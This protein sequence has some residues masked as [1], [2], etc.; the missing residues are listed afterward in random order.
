MAECVDCSE[1]RAPAGMTCH[2]C[3]RMLELDYV[4]LVK[5]VLIASRM[6][7][8]SAEVILESLRV[9]LRRTGVHDQM[10]TKLYTQAF[11]VPSDAPPFAAV[12]RVRPSRS[13]RSNPVAG[14][15]RLCQSY[16]KRHEGKDCRRSNAAG[17]H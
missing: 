16:G 15:P 2:D 14:C 5:D 17:A 4:A 8:S 1:E 6:T 10:Q 7:C 12:L 11:S 9:V 13:A 3:H